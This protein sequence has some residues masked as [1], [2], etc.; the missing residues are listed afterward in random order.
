VRPQEETKK[1]LIVVRT[2]PTPAMKGVEVS[3]TAAISETGEWLRLH[4]IRY[5]YL[6]QEQRFQKY[7]WIE[8]KVTKANDGRPESYS[9]NNQTIKIISEQLGTSNAWQAR[10]NIVFPLRSHCMC[11]LTKERN[12]K[13]YP[14]L[15]FFRP[16]TI[17]RLIIKAGSANWTPAQLAILRQENLFERKPELELEKIPFNFRYQFTCGH[18]TCKGH[19]MF[20]SDWEMGESFR[21]WKADYRDEWESKFRQR[22]EAEMIEKNDTHFYVGTVAKY[23]GT[24]I[25]VGLFYPPQSSQSGLFQ[26]E[27]EPY[28]SPAEQSWQQPD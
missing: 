15:G 6:S 17:E 23:P 25:I 16:K 2:Y 27:P 1:A 3:C 4:P 26:A 9:P 8:L 11:C 14:T 13:G 10:K 21:K 7:Q 20:C 18:E 24:W 19:K 12:E 5:R 28:R 22:Y